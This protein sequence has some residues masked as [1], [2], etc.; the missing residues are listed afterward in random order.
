VN[1]QISHHG[2]KGKGK[3]I[4]LCQWIWPSPAVHS[5]AD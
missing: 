5:P 1:E 4:T 2:E 3:G